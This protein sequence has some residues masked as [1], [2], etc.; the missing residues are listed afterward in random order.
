MQIPGITGV[1]P[2]VCHPRHET[3]D[4]FSTEIEQPMPLFQ[5]YQLWQM[6]KVS[7]GVE[8]RRLFKFG[9][10]SNG[11]PRLPL[12]NSQNISSQVLAP[13]RGETITLQQNK[14]LPRKFSK[15]W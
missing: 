4:L 13:R 15:Y 8:N 7:N 6:E 14:E 3:S 5:A 9:T 2:T 12:S 11:N 10:L 1:W